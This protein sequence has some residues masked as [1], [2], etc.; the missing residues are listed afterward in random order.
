[1]NKSHRRHSKHP[2]A[3][4]DEELKWIKDYHR[5]NSK[6]SVYKFYGKP[7]NNNGYSRHPGSLHRVYRRLGY[8]SYAPSTKNKRKPKTYDTLLSSG[9]K[10]QMHVKYVLASCYTDSVLQK[11][12][13]YTVNDEATRQRFIYPYME[14]CSYSKY[15][16]FIL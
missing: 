1:M 6:I 16:Y 10:R 14:Q 7:R 3:H 4:P 11:F 2:N 8:T 13:Q 9:I 15:K 12:Y 5:C